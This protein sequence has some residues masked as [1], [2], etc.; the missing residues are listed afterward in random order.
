LRNVQLLY[1]A[2]SGGLFTCQLESL[3]AGV[4]TRVTFERAVSEGE[5]I[6]GQPPRE[7]GGDG[8][9]GRLDLR[10]I[11]KLAAGALVLRPGDVRLVAWS[12]EAV[13]GLEITPQAS[14]STARTIVLANLRYGPLPPARPDV[15]L[16]S[17]VQETAER[18]GDS[19]GR[20][21]VLPAEQNDQER[22]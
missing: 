19:E 6:R 10:E 4:A 5:A 22:R 20:P 9:A 15:N 2:P 18:D 17:D 12:D 11:T 13:P 21:N 1:R 7:A 14:Q 16:V 8:E 3:P